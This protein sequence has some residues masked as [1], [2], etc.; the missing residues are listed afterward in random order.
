M[1]SPTVRFLT[2]LYVSWSTS[3]CRLVNFM[4]FGQVL[5]VDWSTLCRLVKFLE[6]PLRNAN[7]SSE[8]GAG[9]LPSEV[10]IENDS[11]RNFLSKNFSKFFWK[12]LK[13]L[14]H[15]NLIVMI[16]KYFF[17]FFDFSVCSPYLQYTFGRL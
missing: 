9:A 11:D 3:L 6:L 10:R 2:P 12:L 16:Q 8:A 13:F 15:A 5:Y 7:T 4:S 1:I 17:R 14:F